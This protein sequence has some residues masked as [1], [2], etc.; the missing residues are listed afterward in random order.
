MKADYASPRIQGKS[1]GRTES[2]AHL[3]IN[4]YMS[5]IDGEDAEDDQE[6]LFF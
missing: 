1:F 2:S 6:S 5:G 4:E 3:T